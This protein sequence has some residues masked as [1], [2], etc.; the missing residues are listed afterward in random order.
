LGQNYPNPFNPSTTIPYDIM[1]GD[2]PASRAAVA[3]DV[4]DVQGHRVR[5]LLRSA[6]A[7]GSYRV[8][9]DGGTDSGARAASGVYFA[10][11]RVGGGAQTV[12]MI[13]LE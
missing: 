1:P 6:Q 2:S 10:R 7:P 5:S 3:L 11:L 4:Y 13:M 9:W 8:S 12:K